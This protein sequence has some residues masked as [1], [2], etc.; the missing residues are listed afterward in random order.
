MLVQVGKRYVSEQR[1]IDPLFAKS[2]QDLLSRS[3]VFSDTHE[4]FIRDLIVSCNRREYPVNRYLMEEGM[5]AMLGMLSPRIPAASRGPARLEPAARPAR[6]ALLRPRGVAAPSVLGALVG[7]VGRF[8]RE[9]KAA[10]RAEAAGPDAYYEELFPPVEKLEKWV[11]GEKY[12]L[13]KYS[14]VPTWVPETEVGKYRFT[15]RGYE[16]RDEDGSWTNYAQMPEDTSHL[17]D[18]QRERLILELRGQ[19]SFNLSDGIDEEGFRPLPKVPPLEKWPFYRVELSESETEDQLAEFQELTLTEDLPRAFFLAQRWK[20]ANEGRRHLGYGVN[21]TINDVANMNGTVLGFKALVE[22]LKRTSKFRRRKEEDA[23]PSDAERLLALQCTSLLGTAKGSAIALWFHVPERKKLLVDLCLGDD[24][25]DQ[26]L[27]AE[28][29]LL[30][31][32]MSKAKANGAEALWCRSRR[33]ESGKVFL[34]PS[35]RSLGFTAVPIEEQE[36]EEWETLGKFEQ[37]T[38]DTEAVPGLKLWMTTRDLEAFLPGAN[39]WCEEMGATDINEVAENK[40][41][42]ADYLEEKGL[43]PD[44]RLKLVQ[45]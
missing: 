12:I 8:R 22:Q 9:A 26:G 32:L 45:F 23:M 35:M 34:P 37:K 43:T 40:Y 28:E 33:T 15:Q 41:D 19:I 1:E 20:S 24:C 30:R 36:E 4:E 14:N 31:L 27:Y 13:V 29:M 25:M 7:A 2:M 39:Q 16:S 3:K 17:T 44:Q 38:E 21:T 42:L 18:A 6:R 11:D 10:R 5:K